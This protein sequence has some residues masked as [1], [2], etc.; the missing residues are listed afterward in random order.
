MNE[1]AAKGCMQSGTYST[2]PSSGALSEAAHWK[3]RAR[4]ITSHVG[5]RRRYER[6][7]G[8]YRNA[9]STLN[10][11]ASVHPKTRTCAASSSAAVEET[12]RDE[13][14]ATDR[15]MFCVNI[16]RE[17]IPIFQTA[18]SA[19]FIHAPPDHP[20]SFREITLMPSGRSTK[21]RTTIVKFL[22]I[23]NRI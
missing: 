16:L 13:G 9:P 22:F 2:A 6:R 11:I 3:E 7:V 10:V 14:A 15:I 1:R 4:A 17:F 5:C 21:Y 18:P 19:A 12:G 8:Y 20:I 23:L